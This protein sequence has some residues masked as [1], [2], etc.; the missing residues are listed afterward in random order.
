MTVLA[1][2]PKRGEAFPCDGYFAE[3]TLF[4]SPLFL[5]D[6]PEAMDRLQAVRGKEI[7]PHGVLPEEAAARLTACG[8]LKKDPDG[9]LHWIASIHAPRPLH[10]IR[11]QLSG[12]E[13]I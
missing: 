4:L 5:H 11:P 8:A 1:L 3:G 10:E 9:E 2:T 7:L 13:Y 6:F 12:D